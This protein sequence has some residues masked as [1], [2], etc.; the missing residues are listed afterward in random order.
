MIHMMTSKEKCTEN[1]VCGRAILVILSFAVMVL[2]ILIFIIMVGSA[3]VSGMC[4][5]VKKLNTD[6]VGVLYDFTDLEK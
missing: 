2:T 1:I 3:I 4:G 5:I 6:E